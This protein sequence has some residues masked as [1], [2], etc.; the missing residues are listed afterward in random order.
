MP[1]SRTLHRVLDARDEILGE[2][3]ED[4]LRFLHA[5]LAQCGLPYRQPK[6]SAVEYQRKNGAAAVIIQAG[7]LMDP[8][9]GVPVKQGLPYG[10]K[11][12]LLLIHLCTEA[13]RRQSPQITVSDSMSAFMKD[14]GLQVTGGVKGTIRTFKEQLNRLAA[15]RMQILFKSDDR[16]TTVN[17]SPIS[18]F[19]VW[20]PRDAR[21]R[22]LWPTEVE[23]SAEFFAS[24]KD[25]ALPLD[26]RGISALQHSARGLDCYTWLAHRLPRVRHARGD[27]V[28]WRALF[29]QFGGE[30]ATVKEFR[31]EF[32]KALNQALAA[33]PFAKIEDVEGGLRLYRSPPPIGPR[34]LVGS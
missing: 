27:L 24:L 32:A 34:K 13:V 19:D 18:R 16:A 15:S 10:V 30:A 29:Q 21:Q 28:T 12:R 20:F 26:P 23:L 8:E 3:N 5:V 4:D 31:K 2:A 22:V 6:S 11:P 25:H 7:F 14:L 17:T 9:K 33:Y 1:I